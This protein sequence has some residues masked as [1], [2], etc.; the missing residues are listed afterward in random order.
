MGEICFRDK[1]RSAKFLQWFYS[2]SLLRDEKHHAINVWPYRSQQNDLTKSLGYL[3]ITV[4]SVSDIT[5]S[6]TWE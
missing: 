4:H 5:E 6:E 2:L 3:L 1:R